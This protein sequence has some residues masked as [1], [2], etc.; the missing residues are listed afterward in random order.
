M[1]RVHYLNM[2]KIADE[3]CCMLK[4]RGVKPNE[5][6]IIRQIAETQ[7]NCMRANYDEVGIQCSQPVDLARENVLSDNLYPLGKI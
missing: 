5:G 4:D 1:K 2:A 3:I 7:W 6:C